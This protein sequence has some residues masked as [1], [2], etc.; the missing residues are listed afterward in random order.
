MTYTYR[1]PARQPKKQR[2]I[3]PRLVDARA[4][5]G[6]TASGMDG[7]AEAKRQKTEE[8]FVARPSGQEDVKEEIKEEKQLAS[9][10]HCCSLRLEDCAEYA[11]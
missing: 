8:G 4:T 11:A 10:R 3:T 2:S 5:I 9:A 7:D 6:A 1:W